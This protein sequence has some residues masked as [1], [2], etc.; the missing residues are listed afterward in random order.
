MGG[1]IWLDEG[2]DSGIA[3]CPG[4]RFSISL[5]YTPAPCLSPPSGVSKKGD[6]VKDVTS[7]TDGAGSEIGTFASHECGAS[8]VFPEQLSV[9]IVDDSMVLRKLL[10][11]SLKRLFPAW[12]TKEA[13]NGETAL[14]MVEDEQFD[15]IFVDQYMS[16]TEKQLLGTETTQAMRAAGVTSRICGLS[17]ND[18]EEA[19]FK[20]GANS[21]A[22][23]PFPTNEEPLKKELVKILGL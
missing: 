8:V 14:K 7:V 23:K 11:R 9:L 19:F 15:L 12:I 17:A 6:E 22:R 10:G 16:S 3:G 20:V 21:F 2:Y 5:D 13:A 4:T 1:E 18:I